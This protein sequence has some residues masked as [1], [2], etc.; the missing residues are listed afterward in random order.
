MNGVVTMLMKSKGQKNRGARLRYILLCLC[1]LTETLGLGDAAAGGN[2]AAAAG[3]STAFYY[4]GE[5]PADSLAQFERVVVQADQ[6]DAAGLA[7]LRARGTLVFAYVSLSEVSR[8]QAGSL[9]DRWRLGQNPDWQTVIMDSAHPAWRKHLVN[10]II[11]PLWDRGYRAFFLDNLDSYER[12]VKSKDAR[13]AQAHG[14]AQIIT[15]M[16]TRFPGVKLLMNRGF[17]LLPEIAPLAAGLAAESLFR[18]WDTTKKVYNEVPEQERTWLLN[19]LRIARDQYHLPITSIDYVDPKTPELARTTAKRIAAL[20]FTP[21]VTDHDLTS[22]GVGTVEVVPRRILALYNGAELAERSQNDDVAYTPVHSRAAMV[23]E[24]LGYAVDYHDVRNPM[25]TGRLR[26]KYA[27]IVTW[28]TENKMPNETAYRDWLLAQIDAGMKV[29]ILDH[30]GFPPDLLPPRRL[31]FTISDRSIAGEVSL[32][33]ADPEVV[34]FETK[35]T[36]RQN[37]FYPLKLEEGAGRRLFSVQDHRGGRMDAVFLT[38]WGG[39]AV[40]PYVLSEGYA[41][42]YRWFINPF[43]FFKKALRLADLPAADVTTLDGKRMLIVHIDGDGFPSRAAIPGNDYCGKVILDQVL[44][45]YRVKTTV[46]IIEGEIGAAGKWPKLA[47]E[48]EPI[49]RDIFALPNVEVASH[50]YSHPFDLLHLG[51]DQ[52]DGDVNGM[53]RYKFSLQREI[54]G[55]VGYINSR[56]APKDKPVKVFL[57]PGE[58]IAPKDALAQVRAA[59]LLSM[60]GGNTVISTRN[61]TLTAVSPMGRPIDGQYQTYAPVQNEN[62]FTN[63]WRGPFYGFRD[64][65]SSFQMTDK[66]RRLKPIN[67]YFHFYSGSK[68]G[69][70]KSLHQVFEW[71]LGQDVVSVYASDYIRKVEDFQHLTLARRLDGCWLVRSDGNLTTLRLDADSGIGAIDSARSVGITSV[72]NLPQGRYV[73]LDGS[74]H[75]VLCASPA[76]HVKTALRNAE[77]EARNVR[78]F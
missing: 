57:W 26:D 39:M 2:P 27:G 20:G 16:H 24:Y 44:R 68:V 59:G 33:N 65:I 13:A 75:A 34:G 25:P 63:L 22:L 55:S 37:V 66:P 77:G 60:N 21:F 18:G 3:P 10:Q 32:V 76:G 36:V 69:A 47:P 11:K 42:S 14:L 1:L 23:L 4:T 71:A 50:S 56:L 35:A 5:L 61:P 28:F 58:A 7:R 52:E 46:S 78:H 43:A 49:A 70:L 45:R 40:N 38:A 53:F 62:V 9:D 67:I 51:Q 8:L 31:G 17:E 74:G 73:A 64:V 6:A 15:E 54:A 12:A 41:Y 30:L 19:Q 72:R 48:L 29:A